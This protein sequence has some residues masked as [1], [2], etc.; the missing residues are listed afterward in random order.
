VSGPVTGAAGQT[1]ALP[2][3]DMQREMAHR[4]EAGRDRA[5]PQAE[6]HGAGLLALFRARGSRMSAA[7]V[8]DVTP[9][10]PGADFA[11][12]MPAIDGVKAL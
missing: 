2:V 5:N 10:L 1:T 8:P 3:I 11:Q 7:A 4:T 6:A 12:V 9:A